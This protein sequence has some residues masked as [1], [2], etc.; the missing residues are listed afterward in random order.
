[1]TKRS[2]QFR[3][4]IDDGRMAEVLDKARRSDAASAALLEAGYTCYGTA[5]REECPC[6]FYER[7][8]WAHDR[9]LDLPELPK[10]VGWS[11]ILKLTF[12]DGNRSPICTEDALFLAPEEIGTFASIHG[13]HMEDAVRQMMRLAEQ[14]RW[15]RLSGRKMAMVHNVPGLDP[16]YVSSFADQAE[17]VPA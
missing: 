4:M 6:W 7:A 11:L 15:G 5:V 13:L 14:A 9:F 8:P 16:D 3:A 1:M 12:L 2:E 17:A 10:H